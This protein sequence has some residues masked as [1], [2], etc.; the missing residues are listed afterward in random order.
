MIDDASE[1]RNPLTIIVPLNDAGGRRGNA[2]NVFVPRGVAGTTKDSLVVCGQVRALD[3]RRFVGDKLGEMAGVGR[4]MIAGQAGVPA[5]TALGRRQQ[6][7][8]VGQDPVGV[9][10]QLHQLVDVGGIHLQRPA[11]TAELGEPQ[12]LG[13]VSFGEG[14]GVMHGHFRRDMPHIALHDVDRHARVQ[15]VGGLGVA[16]PVGALEVHQRAGGVG[17]LQRGGELGEQPVQGARA[18]VACAAGVGL[19]GQEQIWRVGGGRVT[20]LHVAAG[21]TVAQGATLCQVISG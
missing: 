7:Y 3:K 11:V 9:A 20:G 18:V 6:A 14:L 4:E 5:V 15:Q 1:H 10:V 21:D 17:D 8:P 13:L 2:L 16:H 12:E 19:P